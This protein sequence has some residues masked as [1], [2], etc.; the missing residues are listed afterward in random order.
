VSALG[1]A[2]YMT[3]T[4]ALRSAQPGARIEVRPGLYPESLVIETPV[5]IIG[6]GSRTAVVIAAT[7]GPCL[8]L[9]TAEALVQGLVLRAR[10]EQTKGIHPAVDIGQGRLTPEE[11]HVAADGG[12]CLGVHGAGA[13]G[14]VRR[15]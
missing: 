4:D 9:N 7:D 11:C 1:D 15:G 14:I 12:A 3:I 2:E 6:V 8:R 10:S 5:Q 13:E